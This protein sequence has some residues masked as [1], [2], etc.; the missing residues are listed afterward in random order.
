MVREGDT[1]QK[2]TGRIP[3][4]AEDIQVLVEWTQK[5]LNEWH[6]DGLKDCSLNRKQKKLL[7]KAFY[8][9]LKKK[10]EEDF[11]QA[12]E[13]YG[14]GR[15]APEVKKRNM[16]VGTCYDLQ[17]G[18]DL[19]Q[20]RH[21]EEMWRTLKQERPD[22]LVV[23]PPCTAFSPLQ[24]INWGRMDQQKKIRL[25]QAGLHH[26]RLATAVMKWQLNRGGLIL[27]EQPAGA[28]SWK[29]PCVQEIAQMKGV[30]TIVNHQCQFGL[31]V[32]GQGLNKK[33]T[34]WMS[35]VE[36]VLQ[37]LDRR[38]KGDHP[39]VTLENGRPAAAAVYPPRLCKA[40]VDGIH[41]HF[42]KIE[43]FALEEDEE[44]EEPPEAEEE[45][46]GEGEDA[47]GGAIT[48][49]EK[50]ALLKV[51]LSVGHPQNQEFIR[52]LRAARVR[53][54][55][56][57]WVAKEFRCDVCEANRHPKVPRP[58]AIPRAYQPNRVLG[59]DIFY[60]PGPGGESNNTPVLNI[61]DW[62]TNFQMCEVLKGKLPSEVWGAYFRVWARTFG[63]PEVI[64]CDMGREF[65]GEFIG[66]AASE[67]IVVHQI[68]SKAPWQQ[69]K[70]ERHGGHM[71]E[72]LGKARSEVVV[73]TEEDLK[74]LMAEVEQMKNRYSNR[75]GFAPVQRQ[76]GQWP[77]LP[78]ELTSDD[79][80]DPTLLDG[81]LVD[82]IERLH[83]MRRVAHKAFCEY[84][85]QSTYKRALRSRSR[86][87]RDFRAGEYV[88]VYRVP[89]VR[90]RKH[91]VA[92][93][94]PGTKARWVGPGV[95]ITPDGANLWVSM[96]GELWKVAR[97]QCRPATNDERMGIEAVM[98]ECQEV[99]E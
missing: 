42:R 68:A 18:W 12:S 72:L 40:I 43:C 85:A 26:L 99:I 7:D 95:V 47:G 20:E 21:R 17:T 74:L 61:L 14:P 59:L 53:G 90:K 97:E 30:R 24:A 98:T 79:A 4:E 19:E 16:D 84:N 46:R 41:E 94:N 73:R 77:R 10:E 38:C 31:N 89:K 58:T 32:D 37:K 5:G 78:T 45:F 28:T 54:D 6:E 93:D 55:L 2:K 36:E 56:V 15:L 29:E 23:S 44:A 67:G 92:D 70:T 66:K 88:Y 82:D 49:K 35:N 65:M 91:Y 64:V 60:I 1:W 71:K 25:I 33:P 11:W 62:G 8:Q 27:F 80:I 96:L 81:V 52:F 48:E 57:K 63:H 50:K 75:S 51:H 9:I 13:L 86:T 69:G 34:R 22:I 39:H 76:I 87:W 83:E 3:K